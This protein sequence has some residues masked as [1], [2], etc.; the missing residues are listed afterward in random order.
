MREISIQ[1]LQAQF[2]YGEIEKRVM[3]TED[4]QK[5]VEQ[6]YKGYPLLKKWVE[7]KRTN[8]QIGLQQGPGH[9]HDKESE[10]VQRL[11]IEPKGKRF[12]K[13]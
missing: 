9:P 2:D 11:S 4:A 10:V 8:E 3:A 6:F 13:G 1:P 5:I 12:P 7:Q